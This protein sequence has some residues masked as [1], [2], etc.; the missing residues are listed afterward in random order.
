MGALSQVSRLR[1]AIRNGRSHVK[2][3][4]FRI[5]ASIKAEFKEDFNALDKK[6]ELVGSNLDK[7]IDQLEIKLIKWAVP[8]LLGQTALIFALI[9]LFQQ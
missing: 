1:I 4:L 7:K 3:D 8:M 6:I 9:K 2:E 5:E